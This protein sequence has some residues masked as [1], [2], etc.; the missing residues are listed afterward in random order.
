[1]LFF[2]KRKEK[3]FIATRRMKLSFYNSILFYKHIYN[4]YYVPDTLLG[5]YNYKYFK[6]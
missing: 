5:P 1:M 4:A 6:Y 2:K 3:S